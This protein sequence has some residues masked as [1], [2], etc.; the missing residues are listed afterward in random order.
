MQSEAETMEY[1]FMIGVRP[2]TWEGAI[3]LE[4][5][6][7]TAGSIYRIKF[8][9]DTSAFNHLKGNEVAA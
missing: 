6:S 9:F 2:I 8:F 1:L 5:W 4:T 7:A 3:R